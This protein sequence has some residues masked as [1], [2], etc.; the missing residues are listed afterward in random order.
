M[1]SIICLSPFCLPFGVQEG[2]NFLLNNVEKKS[3]ATMTSA[4]RIDKRRFLLQNDK[5]IE[6]RVVTSDGYT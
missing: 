1:N 2:L 5:L 6:A 3:R 4:Y